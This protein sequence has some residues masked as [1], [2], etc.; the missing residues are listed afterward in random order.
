[1]LMLDDVDK[2]KIEFPDVFEELFMNSYRRLRKEMQLKIQSIKLCESA[3][4]ISHRISNKATGVL[5]A[6]LNQSTRV[7]DYKQKN[8]KKSL[9]KSDVEKVAKFVQNVSTLKQID[10]DLEE[11]S[12]SSEEDEGKEFEEN[13]IIDKFE[14]EARPL[15]TLDE[16]PTLDPSPP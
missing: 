10:E 13:G 12:S 4:G 6:M 5:N 15:E 3:S 14:K 1:M 7:K 8:L 9:T 2:M 11:R 16:A